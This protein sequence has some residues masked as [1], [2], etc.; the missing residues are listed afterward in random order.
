MR[1]ESGRD[2]LKFN[3]MPVPLKVLWTHPSS[4]IPHPSSFKGRQIAPARFVRAEAERVIGLHEFVNFARA[5]IDDGALA[6]SIEADHRVIIRI[7]VGA[8]NLDRIGR[9]P[10]GGHCGKPFG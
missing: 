1:D 4:L 5:L 6:I 8:V 10:L 3:D 7:T 2:W 9:G